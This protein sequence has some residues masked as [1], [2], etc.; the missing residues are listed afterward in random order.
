SLDVARVLSH[1]PSGW[2]CGE[3]LTIHKRG[4]Q[5]VPGASGT[6]FGQRWQRAGGSVCAGVRAGT[7]ANMDSNTLDYPLGH[8]DRELERLATQAR[9]LAAHTAILFRR[10]GIAAGHR[11]LDLGCGAGDVSFIAA[12]IVGPGGH[13]VG[14]DRSPTAID[15]ARNRARR[16]AH[17]NVTF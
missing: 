12:E 2:W 8:S 6:Y 7:M 14:I 17:L 15:A 16:S 10:A 4:R 9:D 3:S 11:V 5:R 13:V 1:E